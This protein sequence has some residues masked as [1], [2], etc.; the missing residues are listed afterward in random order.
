[1]LKT[2]FLRSQQIPLPSPGG[3]ARRH[4]SL[5]RS[6]SSRFTIPGCWA[7]MGGRATYVPGGKTVPSTPTSGG[8]GP[9]PLQMAPGRECAV[10]I[11]PDLGA[12]AKRTDGEHQGRTEMGREQ[13]RPK[14][15]RGSLEFR[16]ATIYVM[17]PRAHVK[18][19]R[20]SCSYV[21]AV[22]MI[23]S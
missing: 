6:H 21:T 15:G 9:L 5:L 3:G 17:V 20:R 1:M 13:L 22:L 10:E 23:E 4:L 14:G 8:L 7:A 2:N 11:G 12:A 19:R 18:L 16:S